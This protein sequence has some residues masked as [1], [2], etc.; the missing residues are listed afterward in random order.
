MGNWAAWTKVQCL[1]VMRLPPAAFSCLVQEGKADTVTQGWNLPAKKWDKEGNL[2]DAEEVQGHRWDLSGSRQSVQGEKW[3]DREWCSW[4]EGEKP[5]M[6]WGGW[7]RGSGAE[8]FGDEEVWDLG[9][10]GM[11]GG[12]WGGLSHWVIAGVGGWGSRP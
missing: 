3:K 9:G 1:W 4:E 11:V 8:A 7:L 5:R 2:K 10:Q 12:P 6:C